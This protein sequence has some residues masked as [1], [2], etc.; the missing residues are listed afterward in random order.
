M[1]NIKD[2]ETN[3]YSREFFDEELERLSKKRDA[4]IGLI[5]IEIETE[6][7]Q[8]IVKTAEILS[9]SVRSYDIV[10][11]LNSNEFG[12]IL[13]NITEDNIVEITKRIAEEL[14]KNFKEFPN[15][16]KV[17][18][19]WDISKSFFGNVKEAYEEL[20]KRKQNS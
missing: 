12:V 5:V 15:P 13:E 6:N 10:G 4:N 2:P 3:L 1:G 11:R 16:P 7:P 14:E 18:I 20:R 9:D 8:I 17:N 19:I